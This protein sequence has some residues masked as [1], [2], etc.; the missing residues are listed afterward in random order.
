LIKALDEYGTEAMATDFLNCGNSLLDAAAKAWAETNQY[1]I[2]TL[3]H[4][5]DSPTWGSG[6]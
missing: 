6:Q 5:S 3:P 4:G 1:T 2:Q